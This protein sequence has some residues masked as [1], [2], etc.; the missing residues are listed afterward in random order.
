MHPCLCRW[1]QKLLKT[2][3]F[4]N[5]NPLANTP[6][7][8][9]KL[10]TLIT[11]WLIGVGGGADNGLY[12]IQSGVQYQPP[13]NKTMLIQVFISSS[14]THVTNPLEKLSFDQILTTKGLWLVKALKF[15]FCYGPL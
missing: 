10:C 6:P 2:R 4:Y 7:M 15:F 9:K 3:Q 13:I 5:S 12:K 14:V 11:N 8:V 1:R